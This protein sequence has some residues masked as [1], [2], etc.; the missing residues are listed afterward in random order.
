MS[1]FLFSPLILQ[2][3]ND[4]QDNF[5][6]PFSYFHVGSLYCLA[7]STTT[8]YNN[9]EANNDINYNNN[10]NTEASHLS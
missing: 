10:N 3:E 7:T 9:S 6:F 2:Q 1:F 8:C 4:Q 5:Y